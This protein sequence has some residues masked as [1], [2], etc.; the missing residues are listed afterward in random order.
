VY[1]SINA[2]SALQGCDGVVAED[3]V[4]NAGGAITFNLRARSPGLSAAAIQVLPNVF[5]VIMST[6]QGRLTQ[7]LSDLEPRDHLSVTAGASSLALTCPLDS[8]P[9]HSVQHRGHTEHG[10][11]PA[12]GDFSSERN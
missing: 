7:N 12:H 3:Y 5:R 11:Q 9:D 6:L 4:V 2:D 8:Q 10:D 1:N